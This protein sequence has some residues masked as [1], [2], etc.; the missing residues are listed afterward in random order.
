MNCYGLAL[1]MQS[2]VKSSILYRVKMT[3]VGAVMRDVVST[4]ENFIQVF[5]FHRSTDEAILEWAEALDSYI[6]SI[7]E[8]DPFFILLDVTGD[9]VSFTATARNESKR[10]F[11][12]HRHRVGYIAMLF[13]WRTSPY[14]ARLFFASLGKINFKLK[15]THRREEAYA[16]LHEVYDMQ[17]N[18]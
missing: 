15:Y 13:E 11:S 10:I 14:F 17:N 18:R 2:L 7:P 1:R 4:R 3:R 9:E 16:W 12:T 6:Q 8:K 5:K